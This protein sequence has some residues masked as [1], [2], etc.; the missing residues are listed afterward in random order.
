MLGV[1]RIAVLH[2]NIVCGVP[3]LVHGDCLPA[4]A[5]LWI[6]FSILG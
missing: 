1:E 6:A 3:I 5:A 4:F 2:V